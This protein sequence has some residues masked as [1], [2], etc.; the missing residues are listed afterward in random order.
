MFALGGS[1]PGSARKGATFS[2]IGPEVT[3]DGDIAATGRLHVDGNV[4][5]DIACAVF[6]QGETG[7]V[8]GNVA[9]NEVRIA[10]RVDGAVEAETLVLEA[11]AR[12]NGDISY[13]SLS[14]ATGAQVEGRFRR[15]K[16][17]EG[18]S[19][20]ARS[21]ASPPPVRELFPPQETAEAAE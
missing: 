11:T 15:L 2:F 21:E 7:A 6:S 5:G 9:A 16:S 12:V 4:N 18:G 10:G 19:R 17:E 1:K 20:Q 13:G 14:I 8:Q 3:V